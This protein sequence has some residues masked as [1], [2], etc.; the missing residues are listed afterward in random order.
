MEL[1]LTTP[2]LLFPAISL[3]LL[4]YTNRFLHL[5]SVIRKLHSDYKQE[6]NPILLPQISNLRFRLNLIR[7]MQLCG[8]ASIFGCVLCMLVLFGGL[9]T[10]G[11]VVF[12]LSLML[13]MISLGLSLWEIK[14]SAVALNLHLQDLEEEERRSLDSNRS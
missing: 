3:L 1:N 13:M 8:V 9:N 11:K 10:L 4:A 12:G 6:R 14:L 7:H 5:A 2:A